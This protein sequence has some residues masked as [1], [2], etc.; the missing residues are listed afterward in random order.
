MERCR[1]V[2]YR[3]TYARRQV[4]RRILRTSS[5]ERFFIRR[6]EAVLRLF[7][8][9]E[10]FRFGCAYESLDSLLL[11]QG[12]RMNTG[13]SSADRGRFHGS[14]LKRLLS[15]HR[16]L[17]DKKRSYRGQQKEHRV[18]S[19]GAWCKDFLSCFHNVALNNLLLRKQDP[20][21]MI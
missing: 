12:S 21:I 16:I 4:S 7:T 18:H 13:F 10:S 20:I 5:S 17:E 14:I 15:S 11:Q 8:K 3:K 6:E 2:E 19:R 1:P 9:S